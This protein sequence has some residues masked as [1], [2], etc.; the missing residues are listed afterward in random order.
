V[1]LLL[2]GPQ[3][4]PYIVYPFTQDTGWTFNTTFRCRDHVAKIYLTADERAVG[5][6]ALEQHG[7][8]ILIEPYSK[9]PNFRWPQERWTE[10]VAAFGDKTV[11]QHIH[12]ATDFLVPAAIPIRATFRE[13][14]ALVANADVYV[15]AESGMC[16]AAAAFGTRQV[17]LFGG[18]MDPDVMA[19]YDGQTVLADRAEGSPC[20][21]WK[22]CAHCVE[23]MARITVDDV[24]TAMCTHLGQPA[25]KPVRVKPRRVA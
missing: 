8:Y 6:A 21:S 10:L 17:T 12:D 4:R 25:P 22:P 15:R 2:N 18:C 9:H 1:R 14:C 11:I 23:A 7:R 19:G 20:G 16:H 13:A 24:R 5:D 3:C